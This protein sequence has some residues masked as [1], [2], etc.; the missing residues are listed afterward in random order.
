MKKD[1]DVVS[2]V[3]KPERLALDT[4]ADSLETGKACVQLLGTAGSS[5]V[6]TNP[7][8]FRMRFHRSWK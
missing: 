4:C 6:I 2:S 8:V 7:I 3:C 1:V 5:D